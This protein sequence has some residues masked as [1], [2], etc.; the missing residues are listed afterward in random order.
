MKEVRSEIKGNKLIIG[1]S[2]RIDS[3]NAQEVEKAA[4]TLIDNNQLSLMW[5]I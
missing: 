2:G 3:G 1:L 4:Q 5:S